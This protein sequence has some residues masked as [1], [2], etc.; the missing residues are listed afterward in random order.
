MN[1]RGLMLEFK[2]KFLLQS[3]ECCT[4]F[5]KK[6]FCFRWVSVLSSRVSWLGVTHGIKSQVITL[7][8]LGI[9]KIPLC[10]ISCLDSEVYVFP[11]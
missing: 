11:C 3:C 5:L 1:L 8:A 7:G 2:L 10:C 4:F 9:Y 6:L